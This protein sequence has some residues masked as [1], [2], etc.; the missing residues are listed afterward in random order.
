MKT[1]IKPSWCYI[2][3]DETEFWSTF[4]LR[5]HVERILTVYA[6]NRN[7]HTHC[8]ELTPSYR[9]EVVEYQPIVSAS[10][11]DAEREAIYEEVMSVPICDSAH[12]RHVRN[13]EAL[14]ASHPERFAEFS[15]ELDEPDED[16]M[17][18]VV[19]PPDRVV[20]AWHQNPKF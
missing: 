3:I 7:A 16:D 5:E 1:T 8:C 18:D 20:E 10:A 13:V 15:G 17:N 4:P 12:Y 6:F 19:M 14:I 2:A 9:L 11:S